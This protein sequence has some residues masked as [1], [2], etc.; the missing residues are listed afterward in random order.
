LIDDLISCEYH[1]GYYNDN[2]KKLAG[3][4][5][6]IIEEGYK[7]SLVIDEDCDECK[8]WFDGNDIYWSDGNGWRYPVVCISYTLKLNELVISKWLSQ[9][10]YRDDGYIKNNEV[11]F[12]IDG[13]GEEYPLIRE[14]AGFEID[15]PVLP[16]RE[17]DVDLSEEDGVQQYIDFLIGCEDDCEEEHIQKIISKLNEEGCD[18]SL[19][20]EEDEVV[21]NAIED[22]KYPMLSITYIL[23][24]D[25]LVISEW[26]NEWG[27]NENHDIELSSD[28]EEYPLI[29]EM[30]GFEINEPDLPDLEELNEDNT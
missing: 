29:R 2:E 4:V 12:N 5:T 22:W 14:M 19:E 16:E 6:K 23:K 24:L 10:T 1:H 28:G 18:F 20:T 7:F 13:N 15:I 21:W 26:V 3:K 30:A 17:M 11:D 9:W 8:D 25:D 27:Y